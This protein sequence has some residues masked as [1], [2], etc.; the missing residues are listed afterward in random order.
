M[1]LKRR[2]KKLYIVWVAVSFIAVISMIAFTLL[3]LFTAGK[4]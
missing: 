2:H 4:F 1:S 3:P